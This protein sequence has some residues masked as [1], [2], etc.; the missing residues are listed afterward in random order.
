[1]SKIKEKSYVSDDARL[2]AEWDFEKNLDCSP[3]K[4]MMGSG[5]KI[6][7]ECKKGHEWQA[8]I[9]RRN[10]GAGCMICYRESKKA[11]QSKGEP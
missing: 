1:M 10:K 5:K 9:S 8:T 6:W 2:M 4:T 11:K 3:Y 7:W